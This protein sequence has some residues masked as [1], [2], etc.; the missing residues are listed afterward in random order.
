MKGSQPLARFLTILTPLALSMICAAQTYT[1]T[2]L[3]T[4]P[5]GDSSVAFGL[6]ASFSNAIG[7]P[8]T[9]FL[10]WD[11]AR[12][13]EEFKD[14]NRRRQIPTQV[15]Y[16]AYDQLSTANIDNNALIRSGLFGS[17]TTSEAQA[18]LGRL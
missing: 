2:D 11:G 5:G 6:N 10:F 18:W 17:M 9:R 3:G 16:S 1:V 4:L 14:F 13:E 7:Y 12:R 15:W 8:K